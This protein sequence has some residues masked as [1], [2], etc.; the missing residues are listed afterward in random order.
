MENNVGIYCWRNVVTNKRYIG[1][2]QNLLKR[3]NQFIHFNN[4]YGGKLINDVRKHYNDTWYWDYE[5]LEYCCVDKLNE[6]EE[7]Y[8]NLFDSTNREKGYNLTIGGDG[9]IGYVFTEEAKKAVSR[10]LK[11]HHH[12][13]TDEEKRIF[14]E[15]QRGEKNHMWGKHKNED[16]KQKQ[17]ERMLGENNPF[18]GKHHTDESKQLISTKNSK[19]IYQIDKFSYEIIREWKSACEA[20]KELGIGRKNINECCLG[21]GNSA[22]GF[23]WIYKSDYD[24]LYK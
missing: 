9:C 21:R 2:S 11:L 13:W 17:R 7:Y 22:G 24:N 14:S 23:K 18:Y 8:I 12:V 15:N 16:E 10:G 5:V 20:S 6:R 3:K 1:Q 4:R 19:P